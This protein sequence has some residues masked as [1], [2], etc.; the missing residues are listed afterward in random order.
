MPARIASSGVMEFLQTIFF[1]SPSSPV[2]LYNA[3][4]LSRRWKSDR[5]TPQLRPPP[6]FS[7]ADHVQWFALLLHLV[8]AGRLGVGMADARERAG[9]SGPNAVGSGE[10]HQ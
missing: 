5:P 1:R 4:R 2:A 7:G 9:R 6:S 8:C 3:S 10:L